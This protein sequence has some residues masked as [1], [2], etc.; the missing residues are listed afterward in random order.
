MGKN[1][2]VIALK[3]RVIS[4]GTFACVNDK[5]ILTYYTVVPFIQIEL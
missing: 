4:E 2:W 3:T 5:F 1:N